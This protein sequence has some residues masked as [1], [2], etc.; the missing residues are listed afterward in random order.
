MSKLINKGGKK[1]ITET[2]KRV[3]NNNKK[4]KKEYNEFIKENPDFKNKYSYIQFRKIKNIHDNVNKINKGLYFDE[5]TKIYKNHIINLGQKNKKSDTKNKKLEQKTLSLDQVTRNL[6]QEKQKLVQQNKQYF[7]K[8]IQN[9]KM[10]DR[11]NYNV[12]IETIIDGKKTGYAL[13]NDTD[14]TI[15]SIIDKN[16][17]LDEYGENSED[18]LYS[19][20]QYDGDFDIYIK[21][22]TKKNLDG[23]FF[24]YYLNKK[25]NY[26]DLSEY[27]IYDKFNED[28]IYKNCLFNAFE[29]LG[30]CTIDID[31]IKMYL[32]EQQKL[33]INIPSNKLS[34]IANKL[35]ICISLKSKIFNKNN[36][37]KYRVRYYGDKNKTMYNIGIFENHYFAI[38]NTNYKIQNNTI[39][40]TDLNNGDNSFTLL[41][42]LLNNKDKY[43][44]KIDET[45]GL[46]KTQFYKT[47]N[48][49]F[50]LNDNIKIDDYYEKYEF[51]PKI[52]N[53]Y[54]I[55]Y[56]DYETY[57]IND[58]IKPYLCSYL[59]EFNNQIYSN[60]FFD[61][62]CG[63]YMMNNIKDKYYK[64]KIN[65]TYKK[66][67]MIAHNAKFDYS[68]IE[69]F[70]SKVKSVNMKNNNFYSS[71]C[72]YMGLDIKFI[73]SYKLISDKL[74]NFP[75][76][77]GFDKCTYD[78]IDKRFIKY[79][80]YDEKNKIYTLAKE[81]MNYNMYNNTDIIKNHYMDLD[82]IKKYFNDSDYNKFLN[83][84][85]K[86]NCYNV[87]YKSINIITYS[88]TYCLIDCYILYKGYKIFT[89]WIKQELDID[90]T[91]FIT[92]SS[93]ANYY[94]MQ[95]GCYDDCY[96]LKGCIQQFIYKCIYGGRCMTNNNEKIK[97]N[98]TSL[99]DFDAVSL[100]PSS[101]YNMDGFIKGIPH[102]LQK[103]Q[104]NKKFLD[105]VSYYFVHID[106]HKI[107]K[108]YKFP[109]LCKKDTNGIIQYKNELG[110]YYVDK[111]HLNDLIKFHDIEYTILEGIYFNDGFNTNIKNVIKKI[112][113]LRLKYKNEGNAIQVIYKLIMN[114]SYGKTI[115][116][117]AYTTIDIID[118]DEIA[119]NFINKNAN[120]IE[121]WY[122]KDILKYNNKLIKFE[123]VT[124]YYITKKNIINDH[125]NFVHIGCYIL[126]NSKHIM[127][128]VICLAENNNINIYYQD[129]DSIHINPDD[130]NKLTILYNN[131]YK[132][133]LI[134]KNMGQFHCDFE[135]NKDK[136]NKP[137]Y[138][139][140]KLNNI[141]SINFIALGKKC[142]IDYLQGEILNNETKKID[143]I[144][145]YHARMKGIPNDLINIKSNELNITALQL[146]D[147]LYNGEKI[148]F[149]LCQSKE[150]YIFNKN[151][152][153][154]Y[155][156]NFERCIQFN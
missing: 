77:F 140:N 72:T 66:I 5:N 124:R 28:I 86:W 102:I 49:K 106:V 128:E 130:L 46:L 16:Y 85:R 90:L 9:L 156:T 100:Y 22:K 19:I 131:E 141:K 42:Y 150:V 62:N 20:M 69:K 61:E 121:T 94:L 138:K 151:F 4:L 2:K 25:Y 111:T 105:S 84:A 36:N 27:G 59:F 112:F 58:V 47:N 144:Y 127:N 7:A 122:K 142:Y 109:L 133:E 6:D 80:D 11:N 148:T 89:K 81:L 57:K 104:L 107:N 149:D 48:I 15:Q 78:N 139:N 116:K 60:T 119:N 79:Y 76:M 137:E 44:I 3:L 93:L 68:F 126:S 145:D 97:L 120:I 125:Q 12:F 92:I 35:D 40:K 37:I 134:G 1:E 67:L 45:N 129:T 96:Y 65:K 21:P 154:N 13:N 56:F 14:N 17:D 113:D 98:N 55:I 147:K 115:I 103:S 110:E 24:P 123:N 31:K 54:L 51:K 87:D 118:G 153:Y 83:N 146:Y 32:I 143:Y 88:A 114:S 26:I 70:M 50:D 39:I 132:R 135:I 155:K 117:P 30:M 64:L 29:K 152:T 34:I 136:Y 10:V 95:N 38:C 41:N 71:E 33:Q 8:V 43:L 52:S 91:N 74:K 73:D 99:T 101:M 75:N 18:V 63:L 108:S 82:D 53:D 23:G